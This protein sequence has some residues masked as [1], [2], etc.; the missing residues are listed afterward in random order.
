MSDFVQHKSSSCSFDT[1]SY[2]VI[3]SPIEMSIK[4]KIETIGIPLRKWNVKINYGIK[5]GL[6]EAFI[7]DAKKRNEILCNCSNEEERTRTD[8]I[9]R[10]ILRGKDIEKYSYSWKNLYLI[11]F[12]NGIQEEKVNALKIEN[13]PVLKKHFDN[14][15]PQLKNRTDQGD[16]PYN[17]RSCSYMEEF[18]KQKII[19]PCIMGD[20][21]HFMLDKEG[22]FYTF[23]PGNI[24]T[25]N[26]LYYL[27]GFLCSRTFYFCF[28][29][30]Y[31]GGGIDGEVKTNRILSFPIPLPNNCNH[32]SLIIELAERVSNC[33]KQEL[34]EMLEKHI[35]KAYQFSD[36]EIK[37]I[38]DFS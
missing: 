6:N 2:W 4:K 21:P 20:G 32:A 1:S 3:L 12:H 10:P 24:I 30:Y 38:N 27:L 11:N 33:Q 8:E 37:I 9:I 14:Y 35:Q 28:R 15:M 25:G 7:I 17:L 19:Y 16:S 29:K 5:T 26:D 31:M 13:Y 18:N 22:I 23:A 36:D 34:Y